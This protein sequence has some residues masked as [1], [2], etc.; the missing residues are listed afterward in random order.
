MSPI[1]NNA[2]IEMKCGRRQQTDEKEKTIELSFS[3]SEF[4]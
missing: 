4:G 3:Q 1:L 2:R